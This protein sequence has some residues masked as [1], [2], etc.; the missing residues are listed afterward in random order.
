MSEY[1]LRIWCPR[2]ISDRDLW[3]LPGQTDKYG[4]KETQ[5]WMDWPH[6]EKGPSKFVLQWIPSR[7]QRMGETKKQLEKIHSEKSW[8]K[9][10]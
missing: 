7:K 1:I 3:Q 6:T 9:L 2:T 4:D 10:E 5:I 8:K